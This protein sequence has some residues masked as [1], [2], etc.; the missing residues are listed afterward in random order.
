MTGSD[1]IDDRQVYLKSV[2]KFYKQ[3]LLESFL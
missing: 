3:C 1:G 2:I